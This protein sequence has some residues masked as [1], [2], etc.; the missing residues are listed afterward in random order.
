MTGFVLVESPKTKLWTI[1][2]GCFLLALGAAAAPRTAPFGAALLLLFAYNR[3]RSG[4]DN[5][6]KCATGWLLAGAGVLGAFLV[7]LAM[8]HFQFAEF[9]RVFR[10]YAQLVG[11][12]KLRLLALFFTRYLGVT[13]WPV[14]A[15]LAA[16]FA[17][18]LRGPRDR[19]FQAAMFLAAAFPVG[20]L[21]GAIGNGTFW[22]VILILLFLTASILKNQPAGLRSWALTAM[23]VGSLL[24]ANIKTFINLAGIL[25]GNVDSKPAANAAEIRALP[26]TPEHPLLIDEPVVRYV[27]DYRLPPGALAWT[28]SAPFPLQLPLETNLLSGDTFL[29]GPMW[30]D[31]LMDMGLANA[32]PELWNPVGSKKWG[33]YRHQREAYV[34]RA[35]DCIAAQTNA[36]KSLR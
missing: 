30:A 20:F 27:F 3:Y 19:L 28:F 21:I 4:T 14:V 23:V 2:P 17:W 29:L 11:G 6:A 9:W 8:I 13:Q 5:G 36:A 15:A 7:F 33:F 25:S 32:H 26:C 10:F 24:L 18:S 34:I 16:V 1:F 12:S 31:R 35:A 22:Y